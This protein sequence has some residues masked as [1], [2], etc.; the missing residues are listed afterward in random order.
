MKTIFYGNDLDWLRFLTEEG[1]EEFPIVP[2]ME[3]DEDFRPLFNQ[4][5]EVSIT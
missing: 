2:G 4:V 1:I 3:L 5:C